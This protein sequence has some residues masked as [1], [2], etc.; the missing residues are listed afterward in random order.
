[1]DAIRELGINWGSVGSSLSIDCGFGHLFLRTR[2]R[3]PRSFCGLR[4][5]ICRHEPGHTLNLLQSQYHLTVKPGLYY[6]GTMLPEFETR[7]GGKQEGDFA[8]QLPFMG[9][10]WRYFEN[11]ILPRYTADFYTQ[12]LILSRA[13]GDVFHQVQTIEG[14]ID[15]LSIHAGRR[16]EPLFGDDE[17]AGW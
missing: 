13:N 3:F 15:H 11:Q 17:A 12:F 8:E 4:F 5:F 2:R 7:S 6:I 14:L 10:P 16:H 9:D 1:M